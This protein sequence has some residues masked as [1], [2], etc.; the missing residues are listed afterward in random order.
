MNID[1]FWQIL[2]TTRSSTQ[3]EQLALFERELQRLTARGL[4]EFERVFVTRSFDAYSWDLWLVAWLCGGGMCSD[5]GFTD[6]RAWL[7]SRGRAT[8]E[9]ALHD[10]DTLVDE[11]RQT[12]YPSFETFSYVPRETYRTMTGKELPDLD[13]RHPK[14]PSGGDW[15]RPNL[16]D[17]SG[18]KLLNRCVVFNEMGH[19]E[20]TAIEQRFP[21]I[22]ALCVQR[23]IIRTGGQS[24]PSSCPAPEQVAESVDPKLASSD[25]GA[26]LEALA[27]AASRAYKK[28]K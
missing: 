17:R 10:A 5:D 26:F 19:E 27:N 8:Y 15:L 25:F 2:E 20:F 9:A 24:S 13:L 7:I 23:G 18:S 4:I 28:Q 21:K 12:D 1:Q 16:K 11:M 3:E 22:W 14:E 6:F